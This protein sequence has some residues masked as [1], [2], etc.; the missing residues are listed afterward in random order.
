MVYT[1]AWGELN[2]HDVGATDGLQLVRKRG[3]WDQAH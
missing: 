1:K 2:R 3:A